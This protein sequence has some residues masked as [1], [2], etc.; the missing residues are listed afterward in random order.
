MASINR[1][2]DVSMAQFKNDYRLTPVESARIKCSNY[3]ECGAQATTGQNNGTAPFWYHC[4]ACA[5]HCRQTGH[6]YGAKETTLPE[7]KGICELCGVKHT[8]V[9]PDASE[10]TA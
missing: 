3:K 7:D 9:Y 8:Y 4:D 5:E 6:F 2:G 10:V 1:E